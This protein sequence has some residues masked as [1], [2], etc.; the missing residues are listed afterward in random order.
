MYLLTLHC[1]SEGKP[2]F[3][4]DGTGFV[5]EGLGTHR[6]LRFKFGVAESLARYI[7]LPVVFLVVLPIAFLFRGDKELPRRLR[8][9]QWQSLL[10]GGC[11][12]SVLFPLI[13]VFFLVVTLSEVYNLDLGRAVL[14]FV[15]T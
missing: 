14:C 6:R 4:V 12:P 8:S 7:D 13:V 1:G 9:Y 2:Q 3:L 10:E 15:F 5:D 11:L